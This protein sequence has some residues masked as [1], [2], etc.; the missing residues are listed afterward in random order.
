MLDTLEFCYFRYCFSQGSVATHCR[1]GGK[2][3]TKLVANLSLSLTVKGFLKSVNT[4]QSYEQISSGTFLW[5]TVYMPLLSM[6]ESLFFHFI[7]LLRN[8]E[9]F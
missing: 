9:S 7:T 4:S 2:Y 6:E 8:V 3:D 5:P 1:Y